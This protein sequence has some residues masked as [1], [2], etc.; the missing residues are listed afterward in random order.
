MRWLL[1]IGRGL[2]I[3][4]VLNVFA[5]WLMVW[6]KHQEEVER[7]Q[8]AWGPDAK[9]PAFNPLR[10]FDPSAL[11]LIAVEFYVCALALAVPGIVCLILARQPRRPK[12]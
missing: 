6:S 11:P 7:H 12:N 1:W 5:A 3:V 10:A 4:A 9:V 8:L 2:L